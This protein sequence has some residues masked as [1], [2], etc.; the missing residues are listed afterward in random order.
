MA[1]GKRHL[2]RRRNRL[3]KEHPFCYWCGV[4][5]ILVS[6]P[7]IKFYPNNT[8]TID[9]IYGKL[10]PRR[11]FDSRGR[12]KNPSSVLSCLRC[13]QNRG[14]EDELRVGIEEIR[15]RANRWREKPE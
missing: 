12:R 2:Q 7:K 5:V 14:R 13:N 8:A 11:N 9:H 1:R 3:F 15:R 6:G 4:G 10:D